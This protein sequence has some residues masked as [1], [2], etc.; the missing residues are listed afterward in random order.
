MDLKTRIVDELDAPRGPARSTCS[1][2]SIPTRLVRQH[3]PLMSPL[4]WDLAH[5][6]NYEEQWLL[7]ALGGAG[8]HG[9]GARRRSTTPSATRARPARRCRCSSPTSARAYAAQRARAGRSTAWTRVDLERAPSRC[10]AAASS[11]AWWPSTSTST[12][13][14][15]LATLQLMDERRATGPRRAAR[16]RAAARRAATRCSSPAGPF[17]HGH[18]R[19]AVGLRQRAARARGRPA[20]LPASTRT[21]SP[22]ATTLAFVDAGGYDDAA[23]VDAEGLGVAPARRPARTRS[24]GCREGRRAGCGGASAGW[25]RCPRTSP[26]STCAGTRPTPT[27]AGPASACPPRPS[28]RRPRVGP[29]TARQRA[30]PVGRRAAHRRRTPTSGG[31]TWGPAPV[32]AYPAGASAVRRA[33]G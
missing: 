23:L 19:R 7:R 5:V 16:P 25:S 31:D 27:P 30:L 26:C 4:V 1:S 8:R 33:A 21:R 2:P 12:T 11:T 20:R 32:G 6:G 29:A 13:R 3:S 15:M 10:C 14:R 28:G 17:A 24:S 22:T 18:R 9:P